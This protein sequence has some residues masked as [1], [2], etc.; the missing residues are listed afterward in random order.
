MSLSEP[1]PPPCPHIAGILRAFG[2]YSMISTS[3]QLIP[4]LKKP[5]DDGDESLLHFW[6]SLVVAW[7]ISV[8]VPGASNHYGTP[9]AGDWVHRPHS[10]SYYY[11]DTTVTEDY[12]EL[13]YA[14]ENAKPEWSGSLVIIDDGYESEWLADYLRAEGDD[15]KKMWVLYTRNGPDPGEVPENMPDI[16]GSSAE[17]GG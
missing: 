8:L 7:L 10:C 17:R 14:C 6:W 11:I 9:P 2:F 5:R 16:G 12:W 3:A 4:R 15:G 13:K 1:R